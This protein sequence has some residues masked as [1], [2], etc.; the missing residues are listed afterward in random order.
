MQQIIRALSVVLA[1]LL[2]S[3]AVAQTQ[4]PT[5][6]PNTVLG[7][8]GVNAGPAQ[9]IP[10]A[11]FFD[12]AI[13]DTT[14]GSTRGSIIERGATGWRA[15]TPGPTGTFFGSNGAGADP[16]YQN[17]GPPIVILAMGQSNFVQRPSYSWTPNPNAT[18]WNYNDTDGNIG[19]AFIAIP[20]TNINLPEKIAS[21]I[22]YAYP[23][24]KV[25]VIG[26]AIGSQ[27]ISHWMTGTSAPD[28]YNNTTA[29]V[30]PALA[31]IGATKID[32]LFWWQG[33][34]QTSNPEQY[35]ANFN[36]V[37]ARLQA[38]TWFP[39]A[40]PVIMFGVAPSTISGSISTDGINAALQAAVRE[41]PDTRRFV[42]TGVLGASYWVDTLHPNAIGFAAAGELGSTAFLR[43]ETHNA[44]L[45]PLTKSLNSAAG[46]NAHRNLITGGDFTVN[47]WRNGTSF[48]STANG[49]AILDNWT[50]VQSGAGV[51]DVLKTADAPTVAQA[52]QFTQHS[53]H[54]DVTT[55]D[56]SIAGVDYYGLQAT[57]TGAD[58]SF[59]GFGQTG[60]K[61][62]VCSFWVKSTITGNYFLA[63]ENSAQNRS[64]A[65]QYV[66]NTTDTW[67]FKRVL[68]QGDATGTW[69]YTPTGVGLRALWTIASSD[70]YL[71]TGD[72]WNAADVRVSNATRANGM[73]STANNFKLALP[74]CEEG[75]WPSAYD[76]IPYLGI[77]SLAD[78]SSAWITFLGTSSSANLRAVM[79]DE[80]GSSGGLVFAGSP[81][82]TT[83][84]ITNPNIIGTTTND[85][86]AAGS[87][88]QEI[89]SS[90]AVGSAVGL[91]ST[92][93]ANVTSISLTA[94]DWDITG[95]GL[96]RTNAATTL[97]LFLTSISTVSATHDNSTPGRFAY[98]TYYAT[99]AGA[100]IDP[101]NVLG[102]TRISLAGT[103]T[104]YLVT[105]ATF[106]VNTASAWGT[107]RARR[108]R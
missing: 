56:A 52:G 69:L 48:A 70:T 90:V 76:R 108:V 3:L 24:R 16:S 40:T 23:N 18:S 72:V 5:L 29:N 2:P 13:L 33:E 44:M 100:T 50:W 22:A 73:S 54:V 98:S 19:T 97:S 83:P 78:L 63:I 9:A 65:S 87:V 95:T 7:R 86:A 46:R 103:T 84:T 88:G 51:V 14:F 53:L 6:P 96:L 80:T 37:M 15:I 106:A 20:S 105:S 89:V 34:N 66:V 27:D 92:V 17:F 26:V 11:N 102:T 94:G 43:G 41:E 35:P 47:P 38:E 1:L 91:T 74:Q 79:T 64:Y 59:L 28:M 60:A 67:E 104:V 57:V 101:T 30:V 71:F 107:I 36:T 31:A 62:M 68:I 4:L 49:T 58:S 85:A 21:D 93:A 75:N 77:S 81:S 32:A 45:S 99:T 42:Y 12:Q 55:A 10:F 8:L 82:I 39:R 61:S 25:Y